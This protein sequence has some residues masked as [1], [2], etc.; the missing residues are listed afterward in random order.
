MNIIWLG[1]SGFRIEIAGQVLLLDPWLNG[2][3]MLPEDQHAA[4]TDGATHILLTHAHGDH[5]ADVLPLAK[6]AGIPVVGQYDLMSHWEATE[7][8][9]VVGFNKGGTVSLGDVSVTMVHATHSTSISTPGGP[10][11]TGSECGFM[12]SGEGHTIYVSGD[13]D[14]MADMGVFQALHQPDIGILC[15]GGHF[16]MDMRRAAYAAKTFFDFKTLIPCHYRTFPLL[17]QSADLLVR[18]LPG[19]DVVEPQVMSPITL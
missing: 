6:K 2:N 7:G 12:I 9:E 17:E 16:T 13:T 3:P 10:Q 19:V 11:V 4:A 14:V 15:A 1:H 18:E 8:I 5:A